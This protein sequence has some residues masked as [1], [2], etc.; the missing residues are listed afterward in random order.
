VNRATIF[1]TLA[2]SAGVALAQQQ[3]PPSFATPDVAMADQFERPHDVAEHRGDVV[4][5]IY[6]DRASAEANKAL[7]ARLHVHFHPAAQGLPPAQA[8][9]APARPVPGQ[10]AGTRTPDVLAVPVACVGKVPGVVRALIRGQIRS[11]SPDVPVWLDFA[12]AMKTQFGLKAGV[13]NVVV[14]DAAGRYRYAAAGAPTAEGFERL[15]G[16]VEALRRE[17]IAPR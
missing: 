4:V 3:A 6:G 7:G 10:P 9:R 2:L 1:V 12:D 15:V 8:R 17:A 13:P 11:G 5:L 16:A 14:L